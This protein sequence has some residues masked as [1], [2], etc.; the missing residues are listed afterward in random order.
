MSPTRM[1]LHISGIVQGIGFRPYV[2]RLARA[3]GLTGFVLNNTRGVEIEV[4]G[5]KPAVDAFA[6]ELQAKA[7]PL[8]RIVGIRQESIPARGETDF[9]IVKSQHDTD[10]A[11]LISPDI[12]IC[13]D[14]RNELFDPADRRYRYPFINCTN[15]GPR[16]TIIKDLP[17][18]RPLTTMSVFDMC[19]ECRSEYENPA[20]RRFH[21]Q[22]T[23]CPRCGPQLSLLD[24]NGAPVDTSAP[25]TALVQRLQAG[26]IA[27]IKGIGGYHLAVDAE[28]EDAVKRLRRRK[29]REAKALAI[30]IVSVEQAR[31]F[32]NIDKTEQEVLESPQR[33]IVLLRKKASPS[34]LAES[35]A[36]GNPWLGVMLPYT[37]LHYLVLEKSLN[38]LVMT[39]ANLTDEPIAYQ[40]AEAQ[41]RLRNIADCY[42]THDRDIYLRADDSVLRV[43]EQTPNMLRRSRGFVPI[44]VF[45]KRKLPPILA[46]GAEL[47]SAICLSKGNRAFVSQHIGDLKNK[48]TFDYFEQTVGHLSAML[49]ITPECIAHDLHPDYLS[50]FY[51]QQQNVRLCGVQHHHA[52]AVSCMAEHGIEHTVIAV[53]YDGT[54]YGADGAVWG[55]EVLLADYRKFT[56]AAHLQ[57]VRLPGGNSAVKE[58]ARMAMSFLHEIYRG[59]LAACPASLV[60]QYSAEQMAVLQKMLQSGINAPFTSS[61]GR[62]FDAVAA[63]LNVRHQVAYEGQAAIE[64]ELLAHAAPPCSATY[65][66]PI[67]ACAEGNI[68]AT[69]VLLR[70]IVEDIAAGTPREVIAAQFHNSV[71][72]FTAEVCQSTGRSHGINEVVL[73]GG[74]FQNFYLLTKTVGLLRARGFKVYYHT[75]VPPNDGGIALGQLMISQARLG[76]EEN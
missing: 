22:P 38:A 24:E 32:C 11:T 18:D 49:D 5:G 20:D 14:C 34:T 70:S 1:R 12:S 66:A 25:V 2:Y 72:D 10:K 43:I 67:E 74:V 59:D 3:F 47:K 16:Y 15:C 45:L 13:D 6:A 35:V 62:L 71:A 9:A 29:M 31:R 64:L 33:P 37:P 56:R 4:E 75:I 63:L 53:C 58:P 52:H 17:Y 30:M 7:P 27:A 40:N 26:Q 39:S 19:A 55:G 65:P 54:G 44:P 50:T 46:V 61:C 68:I 28:N 23:A 42:L 73:S 48:E 41:T 51:A 60:K 21:A 57:Y 36:P 76:G 69:P 8:A